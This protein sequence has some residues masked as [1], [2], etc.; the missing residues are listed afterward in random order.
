MAQDYVER[1]T[2]TV[3]NARYVNWVTAKPQ[4]PSHKQQTDLPDGHSCADKVK[5]SFYEPSNGSVNFHGAKPHELAVATRYPPRVRL[6]DWIV[7]ACGRLF[8][9]SPPPFGSAGLGLTGATPAPTG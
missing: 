9:I 4:T 1:A 3:H 5:N 6:G 7:P 2:P 8:D